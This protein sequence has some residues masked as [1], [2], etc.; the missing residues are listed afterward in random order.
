MPPP[1]TVAASAPIPTHYFA[2]TFGS[3]SNYPSR[4]QWGG[5]IQPIIPTAHPDV[6]RV[7]PVTTPEKN[8]RHFVQNF[9][10]MNP[11]SWW[12]NEFG[13]RTYGRVLF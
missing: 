3:I 4:F 7:S 5:L 11:I 10:D 2:Q 8:M 1:N 12:R 9:G 6:F 13:R